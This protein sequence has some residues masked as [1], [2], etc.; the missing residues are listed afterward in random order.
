VKLGIFLCTCD[1]SSSIDFKA[2]QKSLKDKAEIIRTQDKLCQDEGLA[3]LIDDT[4]RKELER[5]LIGCTSKGRV[6]ESALSELGVIKE[7]ISTLNLREHCGWVHGAKEATEKA[8]VM[9]SFAVERIKDSPKLHPEITETGYDVLVVGS[10][11]AAIEAAEGLKDLANVYLLTDVSGGESYPQLTEEISHH[12]GSVAGVEGGIGNFSV[13]ISK[14]PIDPERCIFCAKCVD[15]CPKGAIVY[16]NGRYLITGE[17]DSCGACVE[18]CPTGAID[19][20]GEQEVIEVGQILVLKP[21]WGHIIKKG[22]VVANGEQGAASAVLEVVRNLDEIKYPKYVEVDTENCAGGKGGFEGCN[23]C[24]EACPYGAI[25]RKGD[26]VL[27]DPASCEGC[28]ICA[29]LCPLSFPELQNFPRGVLYSQIEELL[30]TNLEPN[31][32]LFASEACKPILEEIGREKLTYP[33]VIPLFLPSAGAVSKEHI[34]RALDL[35]A[36]G[37]ILMDLSGEKGIE[38]AEEQVKFSNEVSKALGLGERAVLLEAKPED[39]PAL[40]TKIG[41]FVSKLQP[42]PIRNKE[43]AHLENLNNREALLALL[44]SLSK[45]TGAVPKA[46]LKEAGYPFAELSIS[47]ACT[48]CDTCTNMCPSEA[49]QKREGEITFHYG[50]CIACGLCAASCPEKAINLNRVADLGK[51]TE[52]K[53]EALYK[54]ELI[55]CKNCG[56]AFI[57]KEALQKILGM[58]EDNPLFN[59]EEQQELLSN[60]CEDCR[61]AV[62]LERRMGG[63]EQT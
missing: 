26:R 37:V 27:F 28:G 23:L 18:A 9:L 14:N 17:C 42:S 34:L 63:L 61:P 11:G 56:K 6:F 36:E 57:T 1:K 25:T 15:T 43:A 24:V 16:K 7:D 3:Y 2:L 41:D 4:R 54:C 30:D 35:G 48:G 46:V 55:E 5:I 22:V 33:A 29:A 32:L 49:I 60:Y 59:L 58:M 38:T 52:P 12:T 10:T 45:K 40:T 62:I 51:L 39:G 53:R 20:P 13:T 44:S 8:R 50:N 19:L 47:S 31:V 21:G